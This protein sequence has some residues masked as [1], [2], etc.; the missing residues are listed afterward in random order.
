MLRQW[1]YAKTTYD[2]RTGL[3]TMDLG[4]MYRVRFHHGPA[5]RPGLVGEATIRREYLVRA[6][7]QQKAEAIAAGLVPER[8]RSFLPPKPRTRR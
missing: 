6:D 8:E 3:I 1:D 7:E 2:G 5:P 4:S